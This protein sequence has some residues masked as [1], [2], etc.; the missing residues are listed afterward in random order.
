MTK[1]NSSDRRRLHIWEYLLARALDERTSHNTAEKQRTTNWPTRQLLE[2]LDVASAFGIRYSVF[3]I[4]QSAIGNR[5]RRNPTEPPPL[6]N[7]KKIRYVLI[8]IPRLHA[9]F[10]SYTLRASSSHQ[11][12]TYVHLSMI[13]DYRLQIMIS[14]YIRIGT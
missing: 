13:S 4:R 12:G 6:T 10:A 1:K 14:T 2:L 11:I 3:G 9:V 5:H 8:A 7:E